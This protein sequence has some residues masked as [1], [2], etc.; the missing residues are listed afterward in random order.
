MKRNEDRRLE[1]LAHRPVICER[2]F[3]DR[4]DSHT[5]RRHAEDV[6]RRPDQ[7]EWMGGLSNPNQPCPAM[8]NDVGRRPLWAASRSPTNQVPIPRNL[9]VCDA[10]RGTV[11]GVGMAFDGEPQ[12]AHRGRRPTSSVHRGVGWMGGRLLRRAAGALPAILRLPPVLR[13]ASIAGFATPYRELIPRAPRLP[14]TR[15]RLRCRLGGPI[16][17]GWPAGWC[18]GDEAKPRFSV[19]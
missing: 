6:G 14:G 12:A 15:A 5:T 17:S 11:E 7:W 16:S 2:R 3:R 9:S 8:G 13:S 10:S 19:D 1:R 18:D 4:D